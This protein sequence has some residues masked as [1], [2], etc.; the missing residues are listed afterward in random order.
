MDRSLNAI[1]ENKYGTNYDK[2]EIN[3]KSYHDAYPLLEHL[4]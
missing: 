3:K 2:E 1:H 4:Y